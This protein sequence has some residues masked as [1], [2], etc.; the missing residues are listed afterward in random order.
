MANLLDG[1]QYRELKAQLPSWR[2]DENYTEWL[3]C[4]NSNVFPSH[5]EFRVKPKLFYVVSFNG[6]LDTETEDKTKAMSRVAKLIE[7][8]FTVS[9]SKEDATVPGVSQWLTDNDIQFKLAGSEKWLSG[10]YLPG[11]AVSAA[12]KF[13]KRPDTYYQVDVKNGI[14]QSI[15][16]FDDVDELSKY[17]DQKLRTSENNFVITRRPYGIN[18]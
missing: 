5:T 8:G 7:D 3:D 16:T 18:L 6:K 11:V 9:V 14:A 1:L 12:I 10:M 15:L 2:H 13:R 17:L 4:G